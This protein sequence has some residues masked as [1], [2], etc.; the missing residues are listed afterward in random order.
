M[1]DEFTAAPPGY[2][3]RRRIAKAAK[4]D[5]KSR[6]KAQKQG[7]KT[8][9]AAFTATRAG[10]RKMSRAQRWQV[11]EGRL[12]RAHLAAMAMQ[13]VSGHFNEVDRIVG[14]SDEATTRQLLPDA[15]KRPQILQWNPAKMVRTAASRWAAVRRG[16][17]ELKAAYAL[18][19]KEAAAMSPDA[20][21]AIGANNRMTVT[22]LQGMAERGMQQVLTGGPSTLDPEFQQQAYEQLGVQQPGAQQDVPLGERETGEFPIPQAVLQEQI[23]RLKLEVKALQDQ[24]ARLQEQ[25]QQLRYLVFEQH[26]QLQEQQQQSPEKKGQETESPEARPEAKPAPE[27]SQSQAEQPFQ[28][29]EAQGPTTEQPGARQPEAREPVSQELPVQQ[30]EAGQERQA[31]QAAGTQKPYSGRHRPSQVDPRSDGLTEQWVDAAARRTSEQPQAPAAGGPPADQPSVNTNGQVAGQQLT[32]EH[33]DAAYVAMSGVVDA[34]GSDST[35]ARVTAEGSGK[36]GPH[37]KGP[38]VET[39]APQ[40]EQ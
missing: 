19:A 17:K 22:R 35:K 8:A 37:R 28:E 11:G 33:V 40:A 1:S 21:Q 29:A 26:Q 5:R 16:T 9:A 31:P 7:R 15:N 4:R 2:R 36:S 34:Q 38:G 24:I 18:A 10:V 23:Q 14:L 6:W 25:N 27:Q 13:H 32:G 3:D 20:L 30:P 39:A 12:T